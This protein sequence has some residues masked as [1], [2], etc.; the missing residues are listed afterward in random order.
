MLNF[1][2]SLVIS[3]ICSYGLAVTLVEKGKDWPVRTFVI[4]F[5]RWL[6]KHIHRKAHRLLNCTVCT[7]FWSALFVDII[8]LIISRGEYFF[9]PF[10]GFA[11]VGFTWTI[12][13]FLSVMENKEQGL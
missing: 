12:Y 1:F 2:F 13:E 6:Q 11:T 9:W 8:L 3:I 10:S 5:K 4:P 7:S